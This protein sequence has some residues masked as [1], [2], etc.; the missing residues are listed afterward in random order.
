V[1]RRIGWAGITLVML[2]MV[3]HVFGTVRAYEER[4]RI[5]AG[6]IIAATGANIRVLV[7][8]DEFTAQSLLPLYYR[9]IVFLADKPEQGR[10][11][12][13]KLIDG[14][15]ADVLL[16]SRSL[17]PSIQLSPLQ[18]QRVTRSGRYNVQHWSR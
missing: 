1:E 8:D 15:I 10:R 16:I 13:A 5:D 18:L 14:K 11:L 3:T 7:A 6:P 12:A 9:R 4:N 2:A 17:T